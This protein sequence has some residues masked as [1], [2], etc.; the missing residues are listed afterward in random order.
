[1]IINV[2][3]L[4]LRKPLRKLTEQIKVKVWLFQEKAV[5]LQKQTTPINIP[6]SI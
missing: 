5:S 4:L 3:E 1:M 6:T 2:S